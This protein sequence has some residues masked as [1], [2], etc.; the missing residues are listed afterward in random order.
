MATKG[1]F[2]T[3]TN[4]QRKEGHPDHAQSFQ[5]IPQN[6]G[7]RGISLT[8]TATTITL[9]TSQVEDM[10]GC[11]LHIQVEKSNNMIDICC[12][13]RERILEIIEKDFYLS[14]S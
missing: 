11:F 3:F 12:K 7:G 10:L 6:H 1:G 2:I 8:G 14:L 13:E 5:T 4:N 9:I